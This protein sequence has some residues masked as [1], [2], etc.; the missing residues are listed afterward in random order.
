M[1]SAAEPGNRFTLLIPDPAHVGVTIYDAKDPDTF[2]P[3]V[4][5]V[6]PPA[7]APN[8][9]LI[10][11]DD[12]GFGGVQRVRR[13]VHPDEGYHLT[14]DLADRVIAWIRQQKTLIPGKPFFLHFTPGAAHAPHHVPREWI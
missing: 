9:L 4:Q 7:G 5:Q 6:R 2:F 13:A 12:V 3:P 14:E 8:V 11:L 1:T 10:V